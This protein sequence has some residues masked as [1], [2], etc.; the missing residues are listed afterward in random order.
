MLV[1]FA[2]VFA[3]QLVEIVQLYPLLVTTILLQFVHAVIFC[4]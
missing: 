4:N 3:G 2:C 1:V